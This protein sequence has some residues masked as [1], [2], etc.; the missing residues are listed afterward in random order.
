MLGLT[1]LIESLFG[2]VSVASHHPSA[3]ILI[4]KKNAAHTPFFEF[5]L[6]AP[7]PLQNLEGQIKEV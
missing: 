2:N 5:T 6:F 4:H 1:H 7:K 3:T